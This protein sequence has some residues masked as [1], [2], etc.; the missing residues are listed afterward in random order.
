VTIT[1]SDF[2][3]DVVPAF[4]RHWWYGGYLICDSG[5]WIET[6]PKKHTDI[7]SPGERVA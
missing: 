3:V 4:E 6:N 2:A 1:F 5:S 7:S